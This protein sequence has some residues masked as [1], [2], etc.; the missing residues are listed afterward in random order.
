MVFVLYP[1]F[2]LFPDLEVTRFSLGAHTTVH[3]AA[4]TTREGLL[5]QLNY[6]ITETSG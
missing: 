5:F 4:G 2:V 6:L 3:P 1:L